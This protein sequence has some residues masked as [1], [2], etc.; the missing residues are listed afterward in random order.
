MKRKVIISKT[1]EKKLEK[2]FEY[3]TEKWSEKIK[4]EFLEELKKR[5][6]VVN[7]KTK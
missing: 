6:I 3:L 1:A 5:G 4:I 2:L 7:I